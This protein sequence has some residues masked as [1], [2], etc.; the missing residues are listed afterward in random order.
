MFNITKINPCLL[1]AL[2]LMCSAVSYAEV[3]DNK[4]TWPNGSQLAVSLSYDDALNSQ[5]DNVIPVLDQYNL[6]ASFYVVTGSPVLL[7]R[8]A[9]WQAAALNG[10]ELGNHS[11]NHPC[12]ASLPNREWVQQAQNLDRYTVKQMLTELEQAN[13]FLTTID[14]K[15]ERT[16]TVPCGDLLIG[17]KPYLD[18]IRHLFVAIK[19]HNSNLRFSPIIYPTG[20]TGKQ[21]I[22]Y[23]QQLP[24]DTLLVNMIFHGV[25]SDYLSVS[26]EAHAELVN[27]LA[28]NNNIY[29]VDS[30]INLMKYAAKN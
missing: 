17:D 24:S 22:E 28:L 8:K 25:G 4:F 16:Y 29:Y 21:L 11:V 7:Q 26:A 20:E 30:Y 6:K 27:F 5:L 12:S 2:A 14:G 15:T 3:P 18:K 13:A 9:E 19:G 10:H 23:I 1:I